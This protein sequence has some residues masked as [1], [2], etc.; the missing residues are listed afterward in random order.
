[1]LTFK[2]KKENFFE[3]TE[4]KEISKTSLEE[5]KKQL[6]TQINVLQSKLDDIN[7]AL[8]LEVSV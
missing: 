8:A 6:E 2:R 4:T 1:M 7:K 5:S 3:V